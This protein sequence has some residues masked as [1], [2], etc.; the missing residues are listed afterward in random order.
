[1]YKRVPAPGR[2]D[3]HFGNSCVH[4]VG[5]VGLDRALISVPNE[6]AKKI[7]VWKHYV[8]IE[9]P[10]TIEAATTEE[11]F[12]YAR[13]IDHHSNTTLA[14]HIIG[15]D[16]PLS[17]DLNCMVGGVHIAVMMAEFDVLFV[18]LG[19]IMRQDTQTRMHL[20]KG[21]LE[22]V[23]DPDTAFNPDTLTVFNCIKHEKIVWRRGA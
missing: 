1:M 7:G 19:H 5:P 14:D 16:A 23:P 2:I 21:I 8:E 17:E 4:I 3:D 18:L 15:S 9:Q 6:T 10:I 13:I 11:L 22:Q 20:I 12:V